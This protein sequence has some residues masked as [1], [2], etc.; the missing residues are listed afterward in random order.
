MS[1]G[2]VITKY[3]PR[4]IQHFTYT[5]TLKLK[6]SQCLKFFNILLFSGILGEKNTNFETY[7]PLNSSPSPEWRKCM[8]NE[9]TWLVLIQLLLSK[10]HVWRN[11]GYS[12]PFIMSSNLLPVFSCGQRDT[13][14]SS[15][16]PIK[17]QATIRLLLHHHQQLYQSPD[18]LVKRQ[19]H[20]WSNSFTSD[21]LSGDPYP[22]LHLQ[23]E[24]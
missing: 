14:S 17:K 15:K 8:T 10:G 1:L 2:D 13:K 5:L 21:W 3:I 6:F 12:F 9:S 19:R 24:F 7:S 23:F 18:F 22:H 16:L 20:N 11:K 4:W